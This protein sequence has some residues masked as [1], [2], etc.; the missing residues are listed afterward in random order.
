MKM[1][2]LNW[3]AAVVAGVTL[4]VSTAAMAQEK[5]EGPKRPERVERP[6]GPGA[7][8]RGDMLK[9]MAEELN[10]TAEQKTKLEEALKAQRESRTELRNATPEE[11]R[12]ALREG[13][14]KMDAKLK[15]ILTAEQY[16]K[17]KKSREE[18]RPRAGGPEGPGGPNGPRRR[19]ANEK[20]E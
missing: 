9:R 10:L 20:P 16:A 7:G 5:G 15:E 18:M 3:L 4:A 19:P 17:W 13:R 8:P 1:Q 11:R 6:E 12:A 14:E 2:K